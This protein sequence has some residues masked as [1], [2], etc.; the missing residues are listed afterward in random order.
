MYVFEFKY[1]LSQKDLADIWQGVQPQIATR[2]EKQKISISHELNSNEFIDTKSL[3]EN[4]KWL[5]FKVKKKAKTNYFNKVLQSQQET[6][7]RRKDNL[8]KLGRTKVNNLGQDNELIYSY[9]WPYDYFSLVELAKINATVE[10]DSNEKP[11]KNVS[12]QTQDSLGKPEE[13]VVDNNIVDE[14]EVSTSTTAEGGAAVQVNVGVNVGA[15]AGDITGGSVG[16]SNTQQTNTNNQ[17]STTIQVGA[18]VDVV[19]VADKADILLKDSSVT[20]TNTGGNKPNSGGRKPYSGKK[21][22]KD[23][24]VVE[25]D[26]GIGGGSVGGR[27]AAQV[28]GGTRNPFSVGIGEG[29]TSGNNRGNRGGRGSGG[30]NVGGG[31]PNGGRAR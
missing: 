2:F 3:S 24:T 16:S 17:T 30:G 12:T 10:F 8:L 6:Q 27:G 18:L 25:V 1:T 20:N 21:P 31:G 7:K 5:V 9:N 4:L 15:S 26:T 11:I 14:S 29:V 22:V 28:T 13:Q 19:S 23:G